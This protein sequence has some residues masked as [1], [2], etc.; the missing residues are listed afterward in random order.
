MSRRLRPLLAAALAAIALPALAYLLPAPSV[1]RRFGERRE[2]LSLAALEVTGT[3]Q[4]DGPTADKLHA[5]LSQP[6]GGGA[7]VQARFLL[8]V[9]GRCRLE[10]VGATPAESPFVV[11][12]DGRL[13]GA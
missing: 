4:A 12:K 9:P 7:T 5:A 13:S 8:K 6:A 2:K 3:L 1:L 11:L 10:V